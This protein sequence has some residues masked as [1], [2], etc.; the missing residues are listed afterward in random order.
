MMPHGGS[1]LGPLTFPVFLQRGDL[2]DRCGTGRRTGALST[3][4]VWLA[5]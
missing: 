1:E 2:R 4:L 3:G 5:C